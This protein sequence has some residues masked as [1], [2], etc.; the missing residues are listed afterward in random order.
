MPSASA[1]SGTTIWLTRPAGQVGSLRAALESHG[2]RVETLPL[3]VIEPLPL[4]TSERQKLIDLD[5]YDLLFFVSTN[6]ATLGLDAIAQWWP[7]Y[8]VGILNFAVGPGTAAVLEQ[9]G[10]TAHYPRERMTSEALMALPELRDVSGKK[11]LIV[12]GVG[13]RE[14]IAEGLRAGGALVDYLELYRRAAPQYDGKYLRKLMREAAPSAIVIS[15]ADALDNL[16]L[17]FGGLP[18]WEQLPLLASSPRLGEHAKALGFQS[19]AL[20]EGATDAAI[21]SGLLSLLGHGA[22]A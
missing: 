11:A 8:P 6:A 18:G 3:L 14:I 7:Q 19:I 16:H 5:R 17:L 15:S 2:A 1:L 20:V 12:R 9:R 22:S 10:L 21:I 4:T 13:G